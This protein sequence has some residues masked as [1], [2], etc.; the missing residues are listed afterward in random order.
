MNVKLPLD[1]LDVA[2]LD[3]DNLP[4][5]SGLIHDDQAASIAEWV[6]EKEKE[7]KRLAAKDLGTFWPHNFNV[8]GTALSAKGRRIFG[9]GYLP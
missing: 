7:T 5:F 3:D 2:L 4:P 6:K 8:N 9:P 1:P